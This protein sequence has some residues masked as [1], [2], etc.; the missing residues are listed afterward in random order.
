MKIRHARHHF[1]K[2]ITDV[3]IIIII[4][5][6]T[7]YESGIHL[8]SSKAFANYVHKGTGRN[9]ITRFPGFPSTKL[10]LY[11]KK[12]CVSEPLHCICILDTRLIAILI[13]K[14]LVVIIAGIF[15]ALD[16]LILVSK[17]LKFRF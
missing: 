14:S 4:L 17:N 6:H 11:D 13:D 9:I 15:H 1:H 10:K 12:L 7:S 2:I 8:M 5:K 3:I 16:S